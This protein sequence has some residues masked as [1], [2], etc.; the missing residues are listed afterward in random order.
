MLEVGKK[1]AKSLG[2]SDKD[3]SWQE[4]DAMVFL[5]FHL[6]LTLK[7]K[8]LMHFCYQKRTCH[9]KTTLSMHTPSHTAYV[10]S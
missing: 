1:R 10:T 3:L 2:F 9:S 5:F 4:G 8:K 7:L 6:K